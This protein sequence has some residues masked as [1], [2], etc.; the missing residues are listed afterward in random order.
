MKKYLLL[1]LVAMMVWACQEDDVNTF[2][3]DV[4]SPFVGVYKGRMNTHIAE[5]PISN[6]LQ[7]LNVEFSGD[8]LNLLIE[9]LR[10]EDVYLGDVYLRNVNFQ[11]KGD[12]LY[13]ETITNCELN[14]IPQANVVLSGAIIAGEC[15]MKASITSMKTPDI[16]IDMEAYKRDSKEG[17]S[18]RIMSM[19]FFDPLVIIQPKINHYYRTVTFYVPNS[20]LDSAKLLLRPYYIL[21][22]GATTSLTIG[23]SLDFMVGDT[24][25]IYEQEMFKNRAMIRV[26]AEDSI[27]RADYSLRFKKADVTSHHFDLWDRLPME[28]QT[29]ENLT[30]LQPSNWVSNNALILGQKKSKELPETQDYLVEPFKMPTNVLDYSV[31]LKTELIN[32]KLYSGTIFKGEYQIKGELDVRDSCFFGQPFYKEPIFITGEYRYTKGESY[33]GTTGTET[34]GVDSCMIMAVLYQ[35]R[36]E[37]EFLTIANLFEDDR[38]IA[39]TTLT[40]VETGEEY[41]SFNSQLKYKHPYVVGVNYRLALIVSPS[42]RY[43]LDGSGANGSEMFINNFNVVSR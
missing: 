26:W 30:Y 27:H 7:Q 38:I 11:V 43:L 41:I 35:V 5:M 42:K 33:Y 39:E 18:C 22:P 29:N 21:D 3:P 17:D 10:V 9:T 6:I 34:V 37:N 28:E 16:H 24:I 40:G 8:S 15:T 4:A 12:E 36:S 32:D 19:H 25:G 20:V 13:F 14:N 31:Y 23:D 1:L 2:K